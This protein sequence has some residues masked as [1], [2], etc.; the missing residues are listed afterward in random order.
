M[1]DGELLGK[2]DSSAEA[3]EMLGRLAGSGHQVVTAVALARG[4]TVHERSDTTSVWLRQQ[5]PEQIANYVRT[6]EPLDKAGA[7]AAQGL[8]AVLV[9]RIEGDYFSVVGLPVR[10]VVELLEAAGIPYNFTR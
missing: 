7:Y 2:P 1:I 6:G 9:E 8:G 10:L 5:T 4:E 3:E